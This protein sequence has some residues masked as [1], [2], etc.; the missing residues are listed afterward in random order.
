MIEIER[1]IEILLLTNDCVII[2][3]FG[4]FM[5]HHVD[6]RIDDGD[7]MYL[8]PMRTIGFNPQLKMNDSLLAL[9]YVEA[10]DIS[11]PDAIARIAEDVNEIR[12]KLE[13]DGEYELNDVGMLRLTHDGSYAFEPNEA[14]IITPEYYGLDGFEIQQVGKLSSV[15]ED[16]N[17]DA[18]GALLSENKENVPAETKCISIETETEIDNRN[19]FVL[20][21]KSWLRNAVAACIA[22]I[23]FFALSTPLNNTRDLQQSKID[24]SLLTRI[25][26]KDIV[27]GSETVNLANA[28]A[29]N[30]AIRN[31]N[32]PRI[33]STPTTLVVTNTDSPLAEKRTY[34]GIVLASHV[35]KRGA[36]V[37][38]ERLQ[39]Q[40]YKDTKVVITPNNVKVVYGSYNTENEAYGALNKMR[41]QE[42]F[43]EGWITK[44]NE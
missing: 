24:T 25:L 21:K 41:H 3:D 43:A 37:Y 26:P 6:A 34:Y 27:K 12:T 33:T 20:I 7:G 29:T 28:N 8:P 35:T 9:S 22:L 14:G 30:N 18:T 4:G 44:I 16:S 2:P 15:D 5:A 38:T 39:A 32:T 42:A 31:V 13:N 11:Y 17:A 10:Y 23:V 19:D 1:H 36:A 40:G